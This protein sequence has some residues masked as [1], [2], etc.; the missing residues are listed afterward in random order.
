MKKKLGLESV[1]AIKTNH[2]SLPKEEVEN[3]MKDYPSGSHLLLSG[4]VDGQTLYFVGYKYN[5]KKVLL[6]LCSEN[7]GL[8]TE[9]KPYL[10][11]FP[12]HN[13]NV[14]HREVP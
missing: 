2:A 3:L 6:F 8:F 5:C 11:K 14:M 1:V 7:S 9:G 4:Q 12:D 13:G 10:A